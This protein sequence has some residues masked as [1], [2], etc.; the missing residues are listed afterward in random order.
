[1]YLR[2]CSYNIHSVTIALSI[3]GI[4]NDYHILHFDISFMSNF[5]TSQTHDTDFN[6]CMLRRSKVQL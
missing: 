3:R 4:Y 1:M 5:Q 6:L 2:P